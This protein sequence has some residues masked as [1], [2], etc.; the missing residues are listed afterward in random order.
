MEVLTLTNLKPN[1]GARKKKKRVGRGIGSG[2][3][4]TSTRGQKGQH[5]RN[6]VRPGFEGGQTPLY[7]R[8]PKLRGQG[9]GAMPIGLTRKVYG[10][11]NL[12]ELNKLEA[13]TVVTAELLRQRGI[14][15][16]R[17]D[18]LRVLGHG[19]ITTAVTI[20]A[21]HVSQTAREKIEA[22]GGTVQLISEIARSESQAS[23]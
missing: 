1:A 20:Q 12:S 16:G 11:V 10:I 8:L 23:A 2:H 4:K 18:G 19:E 14:V 15:K 22:A 6:S 13:G 7:R 3:G 5:A 17:H 9:K 21:Q